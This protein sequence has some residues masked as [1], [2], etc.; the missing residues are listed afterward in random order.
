MIAFTYEMY[1]CNSH[2]VRLQLTRL[3]LSQRSGS[4]AQGSIPGGRGWFG[5]PLRR[6]CSLPRTPRPMKRGERH[7]VTMHA[8]RIASCASAVDKSFPVSNVFSASQPP[9]PLLPLVPPC[10]N[11]D[12]GGQGT[13]NGASGGG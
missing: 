10:T 2:D 1:P 11:N 8:I 3:F 12:G 6:A 4:K 9:V 7:K 5:H 13:I